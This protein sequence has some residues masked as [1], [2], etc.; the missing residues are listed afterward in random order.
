MAAFF[1]WETHYTHIQGFCSVL[2]DILMTK[3]MVYDILS[4]DTKR[5]EKQMDKT[6]TNGGGIITPGP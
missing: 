1:Q 4:D 3:W 5:A 6:W 2:F